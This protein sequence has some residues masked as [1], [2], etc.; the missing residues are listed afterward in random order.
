MNIS[1]SWLP[2]LAVAAA[3]FFLSWLYYSPG[4]P[5]FKAWLVG[6]G[7]DPD[8]KGPTEEEKKAMPGLML[9]AL[10]AT[11]IFSGGLEFFVRALGPTSFA[12]GALVGALLWLAFVLSH[13]LN[14]RFEGRKSVVL[15][16]N[17]AYYLVAYA[18]FGGLFAVWR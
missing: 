11:L 18:A 7:M 14:T 2:F 13:S 3:N 6:A 17:N 15:V 12:G 9:G 1:F 16:I 8:K 10:L 5:W 4:V